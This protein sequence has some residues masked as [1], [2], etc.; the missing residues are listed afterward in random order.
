LKYEQESYL[1]FLAGRYEA[2]EAVVDAAACIS[3]R[4]RDILSPNKNDAW[5][6]EVAKLYGKALRSL[7]VALNNPK[8]TYLP[9]TLAATL[10]LSLYEF[11]D[12][13]RTTAWLQHATGAANLIMSRGSKSY[14]T[15]FEREIFMAH[16]GPIVRLPQILRIL[17]TLSNA[18]LQMTESLLNNEACFL[19]ANEWREVYLSV[20][21][22]SLLINDRSEIAINIYLLLSKLP[23][24]FRDVTNVICNEKPVE[25]EVLDVIASRAEK[26]RS[27][28]V[29]WRIK[30]D[31][32]MRLAIAREPAKIRY[33]RQWALLGVYFSVFIISNR[34]LYAVA[35]THVAELE[36]EAQLFAH[37]ILRNQAIIEQDCPQTILYLAQK[38]GLS[39]GVINTEK[40]WK[41]L[42]D[43]KDKRPRITK[44]KFKEWCEMIGRKTPE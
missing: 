8:T 5:S 17:V 32:L 4:V 20:V 16:A 41:E 7:Q 1:S 30:Y 2:C 23:R 6:K 26:M 43:M 39:N 11:L 9:E 38:V 12:P 25:R 40:D 36:E 10:I 34:M 29:K 37:Q 42:G 13:D 44:A 15:H 33:D 19:E 27:D 28:L 24:L 3:A 31:S 22:K 35:P 18:T 21:D 14:K